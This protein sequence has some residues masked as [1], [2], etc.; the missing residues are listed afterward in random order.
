MKTPTR[1]EPLGRYA[2]LV[3]AVHAVLGLGIWWWLHSRSTKVQESPGQNVAWM[4]PADFSASAEAPKTP[5]PTAPEKPADPKVSDKDKDDD[6]VPKAIAIDPAKAAEIMAKAMA[7][8]QATPA[9]APTP[10]SPTPPTPQP[11]NT[12][13]AGS[14]A[15]AMAPSPVVEEKPAPPAPVAAAKPSEDPVPPPVKIDPKPMA[16]LPPPAQPGTNVARMIT[17][18]HPV[19]EKPAEAP[20][21]ASLLE[22]AALDA[23]GTGVSGDKSGIRLDE[24]D[25]AIIDSFLRNWTPPNA[26]KLPLDQRSAHMEVTVNREG[27]LVRFKLAKT[28]GSTELDTSVV[29]AGN[30][31]DKI[32]VEL[33]ASYPHDL[34][35]FQ[36]NFHVE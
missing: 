11:E 36:V 18:S 19:S 17:I 9:P 10:P 35:E 5:E 15:P 23:N 20:K 16:E 12:T 32:G 31:L 34:Y 30:R 3:T 22:V 29:E 28:S 7:D 13:V 33:P 26:N 14:P 1:L 24:V 4:S 21:V 6:D 25:R 2:I 8:A 27:R